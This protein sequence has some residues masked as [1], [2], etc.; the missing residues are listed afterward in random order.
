MKYEHTMPATFI[1]R[2]NRF[3]AYARLNHQVVTCHVK[4]TGRCKELLTPGADVIL[5]HHPDAQARGRKTEYSL[6][7]VYKQINQN[8]ELINMD[9]QA[10]NLA[11][12]EWFAARS[13]IHDLKR[14]VR[15]GNSR[16]DLAFCRNGKPAFAEVKGVTLEDGGI[17]RF[18]DAPTI[19][20]VKHLYELAEAVRAGYEAYAFFVIAMKGI[21]RFEPNTV[22]DPEFSRALSYASEHGVKIWAYDC[23]TKPDSLSIDCPVPINLNDPI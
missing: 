10:P 2:P 15:F 12:Y 6:I 4:N 20:G 13:D 23:I 19:R 16:F 8:T 14:E 21:R 1:E 17:A 7:Q 22:T 11:A 5:Q 18:P 9:S 3:I